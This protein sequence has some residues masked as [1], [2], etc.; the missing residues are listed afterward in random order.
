MMMKQFCILALIIII[1]T[2]LQILLPIVILI[3]SIP[4]AI[5]LL[6]AEVIRPLIPQIAALN[7]VC[8]VISFYAKSMNISLSLSTI[9]S[10]V[11]LAQLHWHMPGGW[12]SILTTP[13]GWPF[14]LFDLIVIAGALTSSYFVKARAAR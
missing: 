2:I 8:G 13:G 14:I 12:V 1:V 9:C 3:N 10:I 7:V 6:I 4:G 11:L 5:V